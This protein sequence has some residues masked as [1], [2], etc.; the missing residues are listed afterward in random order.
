MIYKRII[1]TITLLIIIISYSKMPSFADFYNL[2]DKEENKSYLAEMFTFEIS[3]NRFHVG[4]VT[5]NIYCLIDN[6]INKNKDGLL[7][8]KCY[9]IFTSKE[10]IYNWIELNKNSYRKELKSI[11]NER[12]KI[13]KLRYEPLVIK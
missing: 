7:E 12:R 9:G 11:K 8:G 2:Y 5:D 3:E 4:L 1:H 13:E 6:A 10:H